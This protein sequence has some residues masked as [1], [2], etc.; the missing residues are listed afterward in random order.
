MQALAITASVCLTVAVTAAGVG[1]FLEEARGHVI[2]KVLA[3]IF[4]ILGCKFE[5]SNNIHYSI[6]CETMQR[7]ACYLCN[8][9][10][11]FLCMCVTHVIAYP[12]FGNKY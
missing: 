2:P 4:G 12:V 8:A 7:C 5:R 11:S 1:V 6:Q 10:E 3:A 9:T